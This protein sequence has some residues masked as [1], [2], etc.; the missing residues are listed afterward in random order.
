MVSIEHEW[1]KLDAALQ[2]LSWLFGRLMITKSE[3]GAKTQ[4][5]NNVPRQS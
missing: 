3:K 2:Y 5:T 1:D 4:D